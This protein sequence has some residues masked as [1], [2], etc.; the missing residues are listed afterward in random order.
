NHVA[1]FVVS[2]TNNRELAEEIVMDIF[3]KVWLKRETL[4][5]MVNLSNYLFILARNHTISCI[6][7]RI[8]NQKQMSEYV[9]IQEPEYDHIP[10]HKD[11]EPD[12]SVLLSKAVESLPPQQQQV[13]SLRQKGYKNPEIAQQM[14]LSPASV[15]KYQ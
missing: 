14:S 10:V 2:V 8:S 1:A 12:Y 3:T 15:K 5:R 9:R 11:A 4:P 6:R 13:F 7:K